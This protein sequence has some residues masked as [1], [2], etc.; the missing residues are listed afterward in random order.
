[1]V[2]VHCDEGL[3]NYIGPES[4]AAVR[5]DVREA[6]T[7]VRAGQ[8]TER[9]NFALREAHAILTAEGNMAAIRLVRIV[10][11][12]GVRDPGM[13]GSLSRGSREISTTAQERRA[14]GRVGKA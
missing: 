8:A 10:P 3:T 5:E 11:S 12:R 13:Y 7:G 14:Q 2:K 1:M 9:R 6:L 4:C